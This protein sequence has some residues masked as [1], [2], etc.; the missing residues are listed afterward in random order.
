MDF[1]IHNYSIFYL[2]R[3]IEGGKEARVTH[4]TNGKRDL[5]RFLSDIKIDE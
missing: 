5:D 2:I 3:D 1:S 4:V